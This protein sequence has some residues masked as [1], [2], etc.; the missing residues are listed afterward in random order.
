MSELFRLLFDVSIALLAVV[1]G[2]IVQAWLGLGL[3]AVPL[4]FLPCFFWCWWRGALPQASPPWILFVFV[5]MAGYL[6]LKQALWPNPPGWAHAID[7]I[8]LASIFEF[9]H[10]MYRRRARVEIE[11]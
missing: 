2:I 5:T 11:N 8:L 7:G 9:A 1:L 6:A 10:V 3:W 4:A